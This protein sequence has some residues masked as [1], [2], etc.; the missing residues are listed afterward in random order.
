M[1]YHKPLENAR[2]ELIEIEDSSYCETC[3]FNSATSY[4]VHYQDKKYKIFE[5]WASCYGAPYYNG[6]LLVDVAKI[7]FNEDVPEVTE[8]FDALE[9]W[10]ADKGLIFEHLFEYA[11]DYEFEEEIDENN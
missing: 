3:G 1:T 2:L 9:K 8:D 7:V 6:N 10:I 4:Y 11:S 5:T